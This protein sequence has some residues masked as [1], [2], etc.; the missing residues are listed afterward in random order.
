MRTWPERDRG[1][2]PEQAT[3]TSWSSNSSP[4]WGQPLY[5]TTGKPN[6]QDVWK[7]HRTL[8][9][10]TI[11]WINVRL[12]GCLQIYKR[13]QKPAVDRLCVGIPPGEVRHT[14]SAIPLALT[15]TNSFKSNIAYM[16]TFW[17]HD[18]VNS[19]S[20][21]DCWVLMEL[22]R[23]AP[24]RCWQGTQWSPV[25]KP[26]S[27]VKGKYIDTLCCYLSFLTHSVNYC[28]YLLALQFYIL[29]AQG[30]VITVCAYVFISVCSQRSMRCIRTW[31][32]ARN[33]MP[34]MTYWLAENTWNSMPFCVEYLRRKCVRSV[35]V[36]FALHPSTPT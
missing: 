20:A 16:K 8:R 14:H 30:V 3:Q 6:S 4:R 29:R 27:L 1:S 23:Q 21:L 22:V 13:K 28:I 32:T 35:G 17:Y 12:F 34:L 2:W 33:L 36:F 24:S 18:Y 10:G 7:L 31:A 5:S 11:T 26:I 25:E 15:A 9:R 19:S